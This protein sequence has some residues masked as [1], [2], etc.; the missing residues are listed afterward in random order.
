MKNENIFNKEKRNNSAL[1][2]YPIISERGVPG[3]YNLDSP[4]NI[5][6]LENIMRNRDK[7]TTLI[8]RNIPNKYT[9]YK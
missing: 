3:L 1:L 7:R 8:I 4:K 2:S 5:I 6:N 9:K